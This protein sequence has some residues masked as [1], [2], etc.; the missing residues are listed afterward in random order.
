VTALALAF[1]GV[2]VLRKSPLTSIQMLWVN[3][4]MD[5]FASLALATE[6]P[7]D[8]L[9]KRKPY[10][11]N[12]PI[13]SPFMWR[14]ILLQTLY[15]IAVLAVVT[16]YFP[17]LLGIPNSF[18][19]TAIHPKTWI[20][21]QHVHATLVFNAFV[22]CQ[23]VNF[24]NCRKLTKFEYNVFAGL[25]NNPMFFL[26]EAIIVLTQIL[27]VTFGGRFVGTASLTLL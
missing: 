5:T 4:I 8:S 26:V 12:E 19:G 23:A 7:T 24:F 27:L 18:K 9:L 20:P 13:I 16:F 25:T 14:N 6:P 1:L 21:S 15:Q 17:T 11:R 22:M 3:L 10:P 2:C